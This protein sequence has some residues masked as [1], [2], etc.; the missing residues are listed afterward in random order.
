MPY[1][2]GIEVLAGTSGELRWVVRAS[3]TPEEMY[4]MLSV[5]CR[6]RELVAGSGFGGPALYPGSLAHEW[7]GRTDDLPYFVMARTAPEIDR[8]VAVT[9]RG[10]RVEL[11][12]SGVVESFGLRF[13]AAA[14]PDGEGPGAMHLERDGVEVQRLP[15]PV[16]GSWR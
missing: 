5:W 13:A 15:Q 14:L 16:P 6:D 11:A 1:D 7:R 4:T 9:D 12:L 10:T 3:G 8:V 2:E